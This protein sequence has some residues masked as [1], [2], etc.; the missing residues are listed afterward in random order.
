M[1]IALKILGALVVGGISYWF[2]L[3]KRYRTAADTLKV[4]LLEGIGNYRSSDTTLSAV[5][6][7]LYPQHNRA[8]EEFLI[9]TPKA[10]RAKLQENWRLYTEIYDFFKGFGVFGVA[11]AEAPHPDFEA[12][13]ENV[14]AVSRKRKYQILN[15]LQQFINEL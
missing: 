4:Q 13:P 8:F 12:S 3:R 11:I 7:G 15:L 6:L 1:D 2:Y 9:F 14:N 5:V 10:K